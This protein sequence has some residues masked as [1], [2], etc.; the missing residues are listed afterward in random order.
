MDITLKVDQELGKKP[1]NTRS[2]QLLADVLFFL[3]NAL[4]VLFGYGYG[5]TLMVYP[6]N[7]NVCKRLLFGIFILFCS[8]FGAFLKAIYYKFFHIWKELAISIHEC[9]LKMRS[10]KFNKRDANK[11]EGLPLSSAQT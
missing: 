1:K 11:I 7:Q 5:D 9:K 2:R 10:L 8:L 4:F 6:L 3:E